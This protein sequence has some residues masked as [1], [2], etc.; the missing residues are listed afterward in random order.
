MPQY[1]LAASLFSQYCKFQ[2]NLVYCCLQVRLG[3]TTIVIAHRLSTIRNAD[4]I[5]GFHNGEIAEVGTH[6]ELMEK[7]GVYHSLVTMQV[8]Y[9]HIQNLTYHLIWWELQRNFAVSFSFPSTVSLLQTFQKVE[10]EEGSDS[11]LATGE[12]SPLINSFSQ[13]S[14]YR[15]KSTRDSSFTAS[16]GKKEEKENLDDNQNEIEEVSCDATSL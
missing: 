9:T 6:R 2:L 12:K 3:C 8:T 14:L 5:A 10:D 13:S 11:E 1:L 16:E 15:R 4:V 7:E